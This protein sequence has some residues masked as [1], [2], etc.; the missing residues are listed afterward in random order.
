[1]Q[2]QRPETNE[3][4]I[5]EIPNFYPFSRYKG[6]AYIPLGDYV[7]YTD[8][9]DNYHYFVC[10]KYPEDATM[11]ISCPTVCGIGSLSY[12]CCDAVKCLGRHRIDGNDVRFR[13]IDAN[14]IKNFKNLK[15][16]QL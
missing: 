11:E 13:E 15:R 3:P 12:L 9:N 10:E 8:T 5:W 1:M 7:R 2:P 14:K 16:V 4:V 6:W